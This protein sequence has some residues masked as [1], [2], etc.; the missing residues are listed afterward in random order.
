MPTNKNAQIRYQALDKCL[1][2]WGRRFY[3]E[4]LVDACN[5]ALYLY[6]GS[7]IKGEGVKK[8]QVQTD[9][10]FLESEEGYRMMIDRIRDGHRVYFRY[11][12]RGDSINNQPLNQEEID[13]MHDALLLLKRFQG[14][15]QFDWLEDVENCLYSTSKLGENIKSVVSFQHNPYL[16]GM[17][18][19]YQLVFDAIVNKRVI[20]MVYHP[21]GKEVRTVTVSPYYLKQYNNR[22]FLIAKRDDFDYL[23]NFAIDRI[24]G[25]N[26]TAKRFEPLADDFDFDEFFADVVGVSVTGEPPLDIVL[27]VKDSALG[28]IVTKPLHESQSSHPKHLADG[29]WEITIKAQDNYELQSLLRSFGEQIE[30]VAPESLREKMKE[31]AQKLCEVY[32]DHHCTNI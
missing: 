30:V 4:D 32:H 1:S 2:N 17:T 26:E 7:S 19:F 9:L 25:V 5:D 13:L 10:D 18:S 22:W 24:E 11:A 27:K 21:F 29:D 31:T 28:Y 15:P 23:S 6:N 3:I 16:R 8:R 20:E 12:H 14:V